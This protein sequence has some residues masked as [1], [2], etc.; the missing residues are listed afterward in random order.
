MAKSKT[1][2][3]TIIVDGVSREMTSDEETSYNKVTFNLKLLDESH[4]PIYLKQIELYKGW[5][6]VD[7]L[8]NIIQNHKIV[9]FEKE[10]VGYSNIITYFKDS[11]TLDKDNIE[12]YK[13]LK[14]FNLI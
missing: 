12:H 11:I 3:P 5:Y 4:N 9:L 13:K 8:T 2:K 6:H 7:N 10:I 14:N 1:T